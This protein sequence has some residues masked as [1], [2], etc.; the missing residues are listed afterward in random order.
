VSFCCSHFH[1]LPAGLKEGVDLQLGFGV[2]A[3]F[4]AL[5]NIV[6]LYSIGKLGNGG[7]LLS[8][9][10]STDGGRELHLAD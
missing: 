10:A 9:E 4:S 1:K 3:G 8:C 7:V 2:E 6:V 5:L